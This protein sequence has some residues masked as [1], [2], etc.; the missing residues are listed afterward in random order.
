MTTGG[1]VEE[2]SMRKLPAL[3]ARLPSPF[4]LFFRGST[5]HNKMLVYHI[6]SVVIITLE[7]PS[8]GHDHDRAENLAHAR[9]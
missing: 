1:K 5:N 6:I 4:S 8:D 3:W 9:A 2:L 7:I